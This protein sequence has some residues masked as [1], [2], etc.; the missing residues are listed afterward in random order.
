[1]TNVGL[2]TYR[3]LVVLMDDGTRAVAPS[4]PGLSTFDRLGA[5]WEVR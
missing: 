1:M 2:P 4:V 3:F 5:R